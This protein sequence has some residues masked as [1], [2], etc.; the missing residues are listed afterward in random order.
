MAVPLK[1]KPFRNANQG[2]NRGNAIFQEH[3]VS[4][5]VTSQSQKHPK[6]LEILEQVNR[7]NLKFLF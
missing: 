5:F 2:C 3:Q 1:Q 7:L 4:V 6:K